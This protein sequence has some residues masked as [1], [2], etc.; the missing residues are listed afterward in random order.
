MFLISAS[1]ATAAGMA[2]RPAIA[3]LCH[4]FKNSCS[5]KM[6]AANKHTHPVPPANAIATA[7]IA[8][9]PADF[10]SSQAPVE[11]AIPWKTGTSYGFRDAWVMGVVGQYVLGVWI[12]N[13]DGTPNPNFVGR[14][15]AGPLFFDIVDSLRTQGPLGKEPAHGHLNLK[16]VEVC[17][18]SGQLPGPSCTHLKDTWFIPGKSPIATCQI[19]RATRIDLK[20]GLRACP[21]STQPIVERV[22]ELWPSDLMK[23]FRR[24]GLPRRMPPPFDPGCGAVANGG[25]APII[26][27]PARGI[28]YSAGPDGAEIPFSA[29][30]D[31]NSRIVYWFVDSALVG[32]SRSGEWF[33]W[34]ARPGDFLVRAVDEQG[35][36]GNEQLH[37]ISSEAN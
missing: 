17:A 18:L 19:H 35:R 30:T 20:T 22:Y 3:R 16:R 28:V 10:T 34:K 23:L 2:T 36:A 14:D 24:I 33:F 12:G 7:V 21:G 25:A 6:S 9:P 5:P 31:G 4:Q 1:N 15:T 29:V 32:T 8:R 37:V 13:F 26:S 27:S 11:R